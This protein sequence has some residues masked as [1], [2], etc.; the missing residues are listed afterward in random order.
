M[1][2]LLHLEQH[3]RHE[4]APDVGHLSQPFEE[5]MDTVRRAMEDNEPEVLL[6]VRLPKDKHNTPTEDPQVTPSD[7]AEEDSGA[8]DSKLIEFGF[9]YIDA[10]Q[11]LDSTNPLTDQGKDSGDGERKALSVFIHLRGRI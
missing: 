9:E 7:T 1:P 4:C 5:Y 2:R 11:P 10:S 6:A 8:V 3:G